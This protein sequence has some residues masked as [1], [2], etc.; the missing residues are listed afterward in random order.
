[1]SQDCRFAIYR[2]R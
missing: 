2:H 1:M